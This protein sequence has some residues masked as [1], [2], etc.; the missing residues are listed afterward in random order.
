[1]QMEMR[2]ID[3][4]QPY[5][6][7]PRCHD[8]AIDAVAASLREFG[9]RQ[10]HERRESSASQNGRYLANA[11]RNASAQLHPPYENEAGVP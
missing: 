6:K 4:I 9:F 10:C 1:M 3:S 8:Q 7:N 11:G 2:S 5:D